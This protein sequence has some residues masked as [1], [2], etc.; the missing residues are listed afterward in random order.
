[1]GKK[2]SLEI[3]KAGLDF[4]KE[5]PDRREDGKDPCSEGQDL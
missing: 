3:S 5:E 1:M 2:E 4:S